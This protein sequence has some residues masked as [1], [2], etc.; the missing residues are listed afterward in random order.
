[1]GKFF[2]NVSMCSAVVSAVCSATT[3]ARM[4]EAMVGDC[5]TIWDSFCNINLPK[6]KAEGERI[7]Y[8]G[9][10][11][12]SVH[13]HICWH[14]STLIWKALDANTKVYIMPG[15]LLAN[16]MDMNYFGVHLDLGL[17]NKFLPAKDGG[18][19]TV[20]IAQLRCNSAGE[21]NNFNK[22]SL[23]KGDI[24]TLDCDCIVNAANSTLL[25]GGGVDGAI[26]KAAGPGLLA[27]Y[28]KLGG[29]DIGKAKITKGHKLKAKYVIHTVGPNISGCGPTENDSKLLMNCYINS[30]NLAKKII[31]IQLPFRQFLQ[32]SMAILK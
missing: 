10:N 5:T 21:Y 3:Y 12:V 20:H 19:I 17:L 22:I 30:L 26:H 23:L 13:A 18:K 24:T 1:M 2:R 27:E 7:S 29:C 8:R 31:F 25:G 15:G 6:P 14:R 32:E 4:E 16:D 9:Y 11:F 28:K